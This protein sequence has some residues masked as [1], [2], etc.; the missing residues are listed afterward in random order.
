MAGTSDLTTYVAVFIQPAWSLGPD[1]KRAPGWFF[2]TVSHSI[3]SSG[4]K[5]PYKVGSLHLPIKRLS[6]RGVTPQK[7]LR[8]DETVTQRE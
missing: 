8:A 2:A 5:Q 3:K 4:T 6:H 7:P 1:L